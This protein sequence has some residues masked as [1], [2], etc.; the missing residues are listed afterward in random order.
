ML[1]H[2]FCAPYFKVGCVFPMI[3]WSKIR[4]R[5]YMDVNN[6]EDAPHF[7]FKRWIPSLSNQ[8]WF[9]SIEQL[10]II[11]LYPESSD[12]WF[13]PE[14]RTDLV[15]WLSRGFLT[16]SDKLENRV[17]SFF[18]SNCSPTRFDCWWLPV[19]SRHKKH[20][21]FL[22]YHEYHHFIR[23]FTEYVQSIWLIPQKFA[24]LSLWV[25]NYDS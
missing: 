19:H 12:Q 1:D 13:W 2:C 10:Y 6:S 7:T 16:W 22:H 20:P 24:I 5:K 9:A 3:I 18:E 11:Q 21:F 15:I 14:M 8:K 17:V 4:M 25:I 23:N